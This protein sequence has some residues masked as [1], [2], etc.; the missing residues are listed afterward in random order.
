MTPDP[1]KVTLQCPACQQH[2]NVPADRRKLRVT[3]PKCRTSWL[4]SPEATVSERFEV[5]PSA[6]RN[7]IIVG[8]GCALFTLASIAII[9]SGENIL[10]GVVGV[11]FFGLIGFWAV[12]KMWRRDVSMVLTR[13]GIEQKYAQGST[14]IPWPDVEKIGIYRVARTKMVG[15]RLRSYDRYLGDMSPSVAEFASKG[16]SIMKLLARGASMVHVQGGVGLWMAAQGRS[17]K[18]FGKVGTLAES[19]MWSRENFGFDLGF[20]WSDLDRSPE[21]FVA[22]L[23]QYRKEWEV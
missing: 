8:I 9:I 4:W 3:C 18:S 13:Q 16:L 21:A 7:S 14:L 1:S 2:L 23:E 11:A 22:L 10:A 12:P 6:K 17:L 20:A 5:R 19:M 15:I